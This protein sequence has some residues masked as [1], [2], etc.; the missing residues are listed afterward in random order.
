[1]KFEDIIIVK[2]LVF[3]YWALHLGASYYTLILI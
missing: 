1:M 2:E 3:D